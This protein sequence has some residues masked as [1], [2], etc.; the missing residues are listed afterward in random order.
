MHQVLRKGLIIL[1]V[2]VGVLGTAR[3]AHLEAMTA[4]RVLGKAGAPVTIIEYASLTCPHCA[5]FHKDVLPQLK[6]K[7]VDTGKVKIVYR[8]FPLDGRATL[9]AM[10]ARCAPPERYFG[11]LDAL[12]RSQTQWGRAEDPKKALAQIAKVGGMGDAESDAC[13]KN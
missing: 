13:M 1:G 9:A 2:L 10:V 4:E 6:A 11:F 3:A 12:F 7:Y 5:A 8:D